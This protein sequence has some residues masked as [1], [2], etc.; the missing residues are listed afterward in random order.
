MN[1]APLSCFRRTSFLFFILFFSLP[2]MSLASPLTL[3][4]N[5]NPNA[6]IVGQLHS[7]QNYIFIYQPPHSN[8]IKIADPSTGLVGWISQTD[9]NRSNENTNVIPGF[10][11]NKALFLS[12]ENENWGNACQENHLYDCMQIIIQK[13]N[14]L[15]MQIRFIL[16]YLTTYPTLNGSINPNIPIVITQP[17]FPTSKQTNITPFLAPSLNPNQPTLLQLMESEKQNQIE[18]ESGGLSISTKPKNS[19]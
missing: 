8:W 14:Q 19:W 1:F 13:Q 10:T 3:K 12:T 17:N 5:P 4:E 6:H 11:K 7:N 2:K 18:S 15:A 9:L 16:N